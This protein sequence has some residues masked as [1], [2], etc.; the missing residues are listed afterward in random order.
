MTRHKQDYERSARRFC[1]VHNKIWDPKTNSCRPKKSKKKTSKKTKKKTKQK[2]G[3]KQELNDEKTLF[4]FYSFNEGQESWNYKL[5]GDWWWVGSGSTDDDELPNEEQFSGSSKHYSKAKTYLNSFFN[6]LQKKNII[7]NFKLSES[8]HKSKKTKKKTKSKDRPSPSESATGFSEGTVKT[9]NDGNQWI[10]KETNKGIKRW[11]KHDDGD[12]RPK[13]KKT[14]RGGKCKRKRVRVNPDGEPNQ[15]DIKHNE[16][17]EKSMVQDNTW[18]LEEGGEDYVKGVMGKKGKLVIKEIK[19]SKKKKKTKSKDRPS[20]SESATGFSEG[21]VKTGN[22]GN[23]WII[24]E[25]KN[26]VKRWV[27]TETKQVKHKGKQY[28]THDNGGRPFLVT[29]D[30]KHVCIYRSKA[31][32]NMLNDFPAKEDYSEM[33][34]EYKGVTKIFIGKSSAK[35]K[36]AKFSGGHGSKFDGNTILIEIS[37]KRYCHIGCDVFEF[38]TKDSI[39]KYDSPVGNNDVPYP[40]AYGTEY[41]YFLI[42]PCEYIPKHVVS[43]TLTTDELWEKFHGVFK[44][45]GPWVSEVD[46]DK[47]KLKIKMIQKRL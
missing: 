37:P 14:M 29:I 19:K 47:K 21:T 8:Y 23:Q 40:L 1:A 4:V 28:L 17:C 32:A 12:P 22:D 34:K 33:V 10:I 36:M 13:K 44:E 25:N 16:R 31:K 7:K 43:D 35:S 24:T 41:L 2:G 30:G 9:G 45:G 6:K 11:V 26:G 15:D 46:K 39:Q 27:K 5:P 18:M 20:P 3:E 38:S 42:S